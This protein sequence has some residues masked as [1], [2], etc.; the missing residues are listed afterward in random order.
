M[1]KIIFSK[2]IKKAI[3]LDLKIEDDTDKQ[4]AT[5]QKIKRSLENGIILQNENS[6]QK[7]K[8]S[9]L[10]KEKMNC[11]EDASRE[12]SNIIENISENHQEL[13]FELIK[14]GL[15]VSIS[16]SPSEEIGIEME[17]LTSQIKNSVFHSCNLLRKQ[18]DSS[19]GTP[20]KTSRDIFLSQMSLIFIEHRGFGH[21][22]D[23][24]HFIEQCLILA[25]D[26]ELIEKIPKTIHKLQII[27]R[28][29][30]L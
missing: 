24:I 28:Y 27:S 19:P 2:K 12:L 30:K 22:V 5:F 23:M 15:Q 4:L 1:K 21:S 17:T 16:L 10:W 8:K 6:K 20:R 25:R 14:N 29:R 18:F 26:N 13:Y 9:L 7:G 3:N 11:L